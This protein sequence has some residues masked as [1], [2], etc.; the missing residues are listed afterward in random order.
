MRPPYSEYDQRLLAYL[1]HTDQELILWSVDSGDWRG[2][3]APCIVKNVLRQV[4]NGSII[5]FHDSDEHEQ[6]DR[7]PTVEAL[8]KHPAG[9]PTGRLPPGNGVGTAEVTI[10]P[11]FASAAQA[12]LP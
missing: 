3:P 8:K 2:L 4:K 11:V 10:K 1:I 9:P 7:N 6:A 12:T 5:I